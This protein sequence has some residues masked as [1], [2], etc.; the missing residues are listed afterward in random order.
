MCGLHGTPRN[1]R[2]RQPELVSYQVCIKSPAVYQNSL[3]P[4]TRKIA[5][6]NR[7]KKK[8]KATRTVD[9]KS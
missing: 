1:V 2:T 6:M 7:K 3:F 8:E 9:L 5:A 4:I